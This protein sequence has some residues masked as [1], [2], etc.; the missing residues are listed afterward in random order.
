MDYKKEIDD[1]GLKIKWIA[2]VIDCNYSS[3]KVYLSNHQEMPKEVAKKLREL[4]S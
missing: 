4:F 1:R 2:D 3:L